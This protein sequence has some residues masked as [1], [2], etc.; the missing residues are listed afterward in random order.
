MTQNDSKKG[1]PCE[2]IESALEVRDCRGKGALLLLGSSSE[3]SSEWKSKVN[4]IN[5][6]I[7]FTISN[8]INDLDE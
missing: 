1:L 4:K 8:V 2:N 3:T 6:H 5:L 7:R